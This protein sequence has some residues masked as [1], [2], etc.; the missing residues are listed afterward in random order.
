MYAIEPRLAAG[1]PELTPDPDLEVARRILRSYRPGNPPQ[2]STRDQILDF[3]D[4]YPADAHRRSRLQGHLTASSLVVDAD[5]DRVLLLHHRKLERW[6]QLGGHCDGDANLVS[7][8]W[9][10]ATE[11][12]G[13]HGLTIVPEVIDVDI[14]EIPA[15]PGEPAHLHL[16]TRF[17]VLAPAGAEPVANHESNALAWLNF[18]EVADLDVDDSVLRLIDGLRGERHAER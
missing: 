1:A 12:S 16:D 14:H 4:T 5:L 13:M 17:L 10:E 18:E 3:I 8:A 9:R 15:R 2:R 6:L 11:E 7:V